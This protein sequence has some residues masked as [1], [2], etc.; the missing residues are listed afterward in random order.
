MQKIDDPFEVG[1]SLLM[2][3]GDSSGDASEVINCRCATL[4]VILPDQ[5]FTG[6]DVWR[7]DVAP[8]EF[9]KDRQRA[10]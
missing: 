3:P 4:P 8:D 6:S 7:G 9:R 1:G 5:Q 10:A 2:Y